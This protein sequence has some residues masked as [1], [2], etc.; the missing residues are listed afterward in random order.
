VGIKLGD[1][2]QLNRNIGRFKKGDTFTIDEIYID[3]VYGVCHK[4]GQR[5]V[6]FKNTASY[7]IVDRR[8][9]YVY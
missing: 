2:I 4:T 8:G 3:I 5:I 7:S 6:L 9:L 1:E